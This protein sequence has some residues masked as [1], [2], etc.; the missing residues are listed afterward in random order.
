MVGQLK[1]D[2][3]EWY[4]GLSA[5]MRIEAMCTLIDLS[6]P[7]EIRF[8]GS[9]IE[10]LGRKDF[11]SLREAESKANSFTN[12][13]P[14]DKKKLLKSLAEVTTGG[15]VNGTQYVNPLMHPNSCKHDTMT[16]NEKLCIFVV[17]AIISKYF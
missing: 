14:D 17:H 7:F 13:N 12:A 3:A 16:L 8:L 1:E 2:V 5:H 6:M 9:L 4:Q 10:H 11:G 15:L